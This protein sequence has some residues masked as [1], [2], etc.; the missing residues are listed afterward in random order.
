M[1]F[2]L[3]H[4]RWTISFKGGGAMSP[5]K[6]HLFSALYCAPCPN[7]HTRTMAPT[8]QDLKKN[9]NVTFR[10]NTLPSRRT[11][12]NSRLVCKKDDVHVC[13]MCLRAIMNYQVIHAS[14]TLNLISRAV[15]KYWHCNIVQ[16]SVS[17]SDIDYVAASRRFGTSWQL[18]N[19]KC[20]SPMTPN[21]Q[22]PRFIFI[23]FFKLHIIMC[24]NGCLAMPQRQ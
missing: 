22:R 17:M 7:T 2:V 23:I 3:V 6:R 12:K 15:T 1:A 10:C 4:V 11:L 14:H 24:L 21:N 9:P 13:I 18:S 5:H 19:V 16:R 20:I 8:F